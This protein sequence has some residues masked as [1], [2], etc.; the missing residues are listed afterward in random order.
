MQMMNN[1]PT[2][3]T[4]CQADEKYDLFDSMTKSFEPSNVFA[5][6]LTVIEAPENPPDTIIKKQGSPGVPF[7]SSCGNNF[8]MNYMPYC[9]SGRYKI[10][11]PDGVKVLYTEIF[12]VNKCNCV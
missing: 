10:T 11:I 6:N 1:C 3:G 7:S 4:C 5:W 8:G 12:K 9:K 2:C